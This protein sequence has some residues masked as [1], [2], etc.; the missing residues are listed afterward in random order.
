MAIIFARPQPNEL[1]HMINF[2]VKG[3][4]KTSQKFGVPETIIMPKMGLIITKGAVAF[5]QKFY[6][7]FETLYS[8]TRQPL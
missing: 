7:T 5:C 8:S 3:M 6:K 4:C 2:R 1:L